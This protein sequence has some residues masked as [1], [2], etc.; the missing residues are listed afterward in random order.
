MIVGRTD[1]IDRAPVTYLRYRRRAINQTVKCRL[2]ERVIST[3]MIDAT[4]HNESYSTLY[5]FGGG[6]RILELGYKV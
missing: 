6:A 2:I 5:S 1:W 4:L 3:V